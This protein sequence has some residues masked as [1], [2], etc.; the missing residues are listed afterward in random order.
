MWRDFRVR[1]KRQVASKKD[2]DPHDLNSSAR[3]PLGLIFVFF[4]LCYNWTGLKPEDL[5]S[6][7][8]TFSHLLTDQGADLGTILMMISEKREKGNL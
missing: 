8:F 4:Q 5:N 3:D 7:S 2:N 6:P 1:K